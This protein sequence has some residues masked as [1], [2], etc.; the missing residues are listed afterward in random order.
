MTHPAKYVISPCTDLKK[1]TSRPNS[2]N[3]EQNGILSLQFKPLEHRTVRTLK[4]LKSSEQSEFQTLKTKCS[5]P[6]HEFSSMKNFLFLR[7]VVYDLNNYTF[8]F[9]ALYVN[10]NYILLRLNI[11]IYFNFNLM[12]FQKR[13]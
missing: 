6:V 7:Q 3:S 2:A 4:I 5:D 1:L 10:R 12:N 9:S 11:F 8:G 13:L